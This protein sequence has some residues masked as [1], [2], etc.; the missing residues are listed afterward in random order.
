MESAGVELHLGRTLRRPG[1]LV[2]LA[3]DAR[4]VELVRDGDE[5]AFE[6]LYDRHHGAILGF[7]RH[8]L[9]SREEAEDALQHT[10]LAAYRDLVASDKPIEARPWLFAIARNRCYS[11]LRARRE[12]LALEAAEPSTEGLAATVEQ[13]EDVRELLGDLA[14]LP[15]DQRAALLL[16]ELG[17]LDHEGIATV[18]GCRREK[19]K[20]L[21]FQARTSLAAS[22]EARET[23][24]TEIQAELAIAS[25]GALRR[26]AL[27]RHLRDCAGCRAFRAEV[28]R[29]RELLCIALPVLPA[30]ALKATVLSATASAATPGAASVGGLAA[31]GS[32][33]GAGATSGGLAALGVGTAAKI[34]IAVTLAGSVAGGGAVALDAVRDGTASVAAPTVPNTSAAPA[35]A[36]LLAS[37]A[38]S[39]AA[40]FTRPGAAS[41]TPPR[42]ARSKGFL[43]QTAPGPGGNGARAKARAF[44]HRGGSA[45]GVERR[46]AAPRGAKR[47][48]AAPPPAPG[49]TDAEPR[50]ADP[51]A[52]PAPVVPGEAGRA[53]KPA[54]SPSAADAAPAGEK[55]SDRVPSAVAPIE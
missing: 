3:S 54:D 8:M 39:S 52:T 47:Q 6:A 33:V 24:C 9:G 30:L 35:S 36:P 10:F 55:G 51:P 22:R 13:R 32:A 53:Q 2:R 41:T 7:S 27:R 1:P 45:T 28:G 38:G 14:R 31:A 26:G 23:P 37:P 21:V 12:H 34:A 4:L 11:V 17:A 49:R 46:A 15:E 42:S 18:L 50:R 19:V 29:Q 16:A 43:P 48:G 40:P 5:R 44:S 20:A 25:G